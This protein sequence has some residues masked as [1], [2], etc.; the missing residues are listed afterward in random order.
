[1]L[2]EQYVVDVRRQFTGESLMGARDRLSDLRDWSKL[3]PA[4]KNSDQARLESYLLQ[5]LGGGRGRHPLGI[6]EVVPYAD[7][8]VLRLESKELLTPLLHLLPHRDRRRSRHGVV[9][10]RASTGSRG[11]ELVLGRTGGGRVVVVGPQDCHLAATLEAHRQEVEGR[12]HVPLWTKDTP[13]DPMPRPMRRSRPGQTTSKTAKP[14]DPHTVQPR[15]A[16]ALLRR[17]HLWNSLAAGS[18]VT[19]TAEPHE[20]GLAWTV[21]R[22]LPS[23]HRMHDDNVTRALTESVAGPGLIADAGGHRCNQQQCVQTFDSARLTVHTVHG[24][25]NRPARRPGR[26]RAHVLSTFLKER[27]PEADIDGAGRKGHVLQLIDPWGDG[28]TDAAEQLA[29]V[30]AQQGLYTLVLRVDGRY[31]HGLA[32][33]SWDRARLTGGSG[34]MFEGMADFVHGDLKADIARARTEFD[35]I[36][37]VKHQWSDFP[38]LGF[39]PLADDHLIVTG[40]PFPRTTKSTTVRAGELQRRTIPLTP[41]ESAMAWLHSR[42]ARVPFADVPMTGLL[43]QCPDEERGPDAFDSMVDTELARHGL[44]VLGRLPQPPRRSPH[45]TVLDHLPAE[46]RAFVIKQGT[47]V[48]RGLGPARADAT[49][50]LTALREYAE[51]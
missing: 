36:I 43:L 29:A 41:A 16:S 35:H 17:L 15:L 4:A 32:T 37:M 42:L 48:R 39:S 23:G 38:L 50:F 10:L 7:H 30:W 26:A 40:S 20:S 3:L 1:M 5:A 21:Q 6:N 13:H 11:I 25:D 46:Q 2:I 14:V 45:R 9:D 12:G 51:F 44:P 19:L 27:R 24:T 28:P 34:A 47:Q 22:C 33:A 8:L 18:T 31:P 49:V